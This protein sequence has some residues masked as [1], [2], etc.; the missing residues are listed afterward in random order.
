MLCCGRSKKPF[1]CQVILLDG[2]HLTFSKSHNQNIKVSS[3]SKAHILLE[4]VCLHL[5]LIETEYFGLKYFDHQVQYH[6]LDPMKP[7]CDDDSFVS[8]TSN[9]PWTLHFGVKFYAVDP[10]ALKEE[11]TRYQFFLQL[12]NDIF[13]GRLPC[14]WKKA[15]EVSSLALQSEIGDYQENEHK[16]GYVSEFRFVQNQDEKFESEVARLHAMYKGLVPATAEMQYLRKCR[17]MDQYGVEIY[18][19]KGD[20]GMKYSIGISPRGIE[21]YKNKYRIA[22]YYWQRIDHVEFKDQYLKLKVT[23]KQIVE[24]THTFELSSL[25]LCHHVWKSIVD[26]HAFYRLPQNIPNTQWSKKYRS[27]GRVTDNE[28]QQSEVEREEPEVQRGSSKRYPPRVNHTNEGDNNSEH[29]LP[30]QSRQQ[31]KE[32]N[33]LSWTHVLDKKG[34]FGAEDVNQNELSQYMTPKSER[35]E[36]NRQLHSLSDT[37]NRTRKHRSH[38]GRSSGEESDSP[39]KRR[40]RARARHRSNMGSD[41]SETSHRRRRRQHYYTDT[42]M[43]NGGSH[44]EKNR[45]RNS[46]SSSH[47]ARKNKRLSREDEAAR[48]Q[49]W[50]HIKRDVVDPTNQ[51]LEQLQDIPYT[52]VKT[53]GNPTPVRVRRNR[54]RHSSGKRTSGISTN[55]YNQALEEG[56]V[57]PLSITTSV[58]QEKQRKAVHNHNQR[59]RS[60]KYPGNDWDTK[61]SL[62]VDGFHTTNSGKA[63]R[64]KTRKNQPSDTAKDANVKLVFSRI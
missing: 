19:V 50:Q 25:G 30:N 33:A 38:R 55:S 29:N 53:E 43:A 37:E 14:S 42:E 26:H 52:E 22:V 11:V 62:S 5:N 8:I 15:A 54:H 27:S 9:T 28:A 4:A 51:S 13:S 6:W 58:L 31:S 34:M 63:Q 45:R 48:E 20:A 16:R 2:T 10:C 56:M 46:G 60:P 57:S 36:R 18:P 41:V 59:Y 49:L 7:L 35:R 21:T 3:T 1:H 40:I 39:S 32:N 61:T 64:V 17:Q 24:N 44:I 23:T 47:Q 12:K